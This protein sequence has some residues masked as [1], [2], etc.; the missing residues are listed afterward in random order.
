MLGPWWRQGRVQD[1]VSVFQGIKDQDPNTTFTQACTLSN[2]EPPQYDPSQDCPNTS[3]P[4]AVA[5]ANA[6]DQVVLA[7]GE[8][9]EMSGE[10]TSRSKL[11]LPGRQLE[12]IKEVV[13]TGKPV[14]VVLF[15]GRPLV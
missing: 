11:N 3:F 7:V 12:L 15:N 1:A 5:A 14:A 6:A 4:D 9:R 8:T 2:L 10:A 13:A